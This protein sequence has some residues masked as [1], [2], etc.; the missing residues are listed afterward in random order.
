M[1]TVITSIGS[2]S[3][4][5][6][7][8]NGQMTMTG[9]SG[10]GTPW[11]GNLSVSSAATANVGDMLFFDNVYYNCGGFGGGCSG[12]ADIIYLITAIVDSTTLTIKYISG[13]A[14]SDPINLK[15]NSMGSSNAQPYVLRYYSTPTTWDAGLDDTGLY[16]SGDTAKGECYDDSDFS[17]T[18]AIT[19]DGGGTVGLDAVILSVAAGQRHD[20]TAKEVGGSGV[21]FLW[22][23][24]GDNARS[25]I[26]LKIDEAREA[27]VEWIDFDVNGYGLHSGSMVAA[28][29][30]HGGQYYTAGYANGAA[31]CIV[32]DNTGQQT[33]G[34]Y[35]HTFGIIAHGR[36]KF[37]VNCIVYNMSNKGYEDCYGIYSSSQDAV[38]VCNNTVYNIHGFDNSPALSDAIGFQTSAR[39]NAVYRNNISARVYEATSTECFNTYSGGDINNL[40]TD[41]TAD[42]TNC[43]AD[44]DYTTLF[45][46]TT[47]GAEDL[48]ILRSSK[49]VGAGTDLGTHLTFWPGES[50]YEQNVPVTAGLLNR[51]INHGDRN[52]RA[53]AWDIGASQNAIVSTIGTTGREYSTVA[54]WT[55]HLDED[56]YYGAGSV[57][58]GECYADTAFT[59]CHLEN[60]DT[61]GLIRAVLTAADGQQHDGTAGTGVVFNMAGEVNRTY[62]GSALPILSFLEFTQSS[63]Y[64]DH[65]AVDAYTAKVEVDHCLIHGYDLRQAN[66]TS[67]CLLRQGSGDN[68]KG[69][70]C[71]NNILYDVTRGIVGSQNCT[72]YGIKQKGAYAATTNNTVYNIHADS[73]DG[74]I[75]Q[76][77]IGIE[78]ERTYHKAINNIA[79]GISS[80]NGT[81]TGMVCD[82]GSPSEASNNMVNDT[83]ETGGSSQTGKSS[84]G[85]FV[86]TTTG[87]EDLHL[88][89]GSD[90]IGNGADLG[91]E[92]D[93]LTDDIAGTSQYVWGLNYD[94]NRGNRDAFS[95]TWDIGASQYEIIAKIGT[96]SRDF[97]TIDAWEAQLDN[98]DYYGKGS[99]VRGE[100]YDDTDFPWS[101][102]LT[103]D[104][105]GTVV[106]DQVVLS[107]A[108][109][110]RHDGTAKEVGGS[111]VR[112]LVGADQSRLYIA[113]NYGGCS[114]WVEWLDFD[115]N[116]YAITTQLG[117]G[118]ICANAGDWYSAPRSNG[119]ANCIIHDNKGPYNQATQHATAIG[120]SLK[121]DQNWITNCIIYNIGAQWYQVNSKPYKYSYGLYNG[122]RDGVVIS[123]ITIYNIFTVTHPTSNESNAYGWYGSSSG[124]YMKERN[125][126]AARVYGA[127]NVNKCFGPTGGPSDYNLST[128]D[129]A[130]GSN[131]VHDVDYNDLFVSTSAGSEDLTLK[132]GSPAL[133]V[134]DDMGNGPIVFYAARPNQAPPIAGILPV[135]IKGRD[136]H[137]EDD[138]WD[139]GA[140][141]CE[142][143]STSTS[144]AP[145]IAF[146]FFVD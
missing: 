66:S 135:D 20:G 89:V 100:C 17:I 116:N 114:G 141:Q 71:H 124:S 136:R 4:T 105:G 60:G 63:T 51:D 83:S 137:A 77:A 29:E 62:S 98:T 27:W 88:V 21:R 69:R 94:I 7:P 34:G 36:S 92:I 133:A 67:A 86:S 68:G 42:G 93:T 123:N 6:D 49:A 35:D 118:M 25:Q 90:A 84:S 143:C 44:V 96:S 91:V 3:T 108:A 72:L 30:L 97:S 45:H 16:S 95:Q 109:G 5:G 52:S 74:S 43:I 64:A 37:V 40:S 41:D 138:T 57:A 13:G 122:D 128:D 70:S 145:N 134:G 50:G 144:N 26:A 22:A 146:M 126:I 32:H 127:G 76:N 130:T 113:V 58:R 53:M 31:W 39:A 117:E 121:Y 80:A 56:T 2:K 132:N 48:H 125:V 8:V 18:A 55:A 59:A 102:S 81:A 23:A 24:P 1:A 131:S 14:N 47:A 85:Q 15:A 54:A 103:I 82:D 75:T 46:S 112:L 10:S 115:G 61:I 99:K 111:G 110:Q 38:V 140:H 28:L 129:T 9:S 19:V 104:G 106:L 11:T 79:M 139:I 101:S 65:D 119:I 87:S 107:V 33:V 120:A 78:Y 73:T 12:P 142:D